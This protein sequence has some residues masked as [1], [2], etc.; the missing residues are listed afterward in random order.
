LEADFLKSNDDNELRD[1]RSA[2]FK[3]KLETYPIGQ[4]AKIIGAKVRMIRYYNEI[5][6]VKPKSHTEGGNRLY[7]TADIWRLELTATLRY[8][9]F[10][11]E[12]IS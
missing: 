5:G 10:G 12:E 9:D 11:I 8:L 1:Q 7:S 2:D 3:H 4:V 6:L